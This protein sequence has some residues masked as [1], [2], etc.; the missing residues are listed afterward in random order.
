MKITLQVS[1]SVIQRARREAKSRRQSIN[2]FVADALIEKLG[3]EPLTP[4][5]S[6]AARIKWAGALSHLKD[7]T[8]RINAIIEAELERLD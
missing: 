5:Q 8:A 7:E 6:R 4:E 3:P 2:Q 1:E